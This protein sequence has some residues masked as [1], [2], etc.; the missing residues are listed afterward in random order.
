MRGVV[1]MLLGVILLVLNDALIKTLTLGYPV[2]QLLFLRGLFVIP[3]VLMLATRA[4][5][6]RALRVINVK[7]QAWRGA[8]VIAGSF[9]FVSGL[10][11]LPL[12]DAVAISFTGPLFITAMAPYALGERVGWRRRGAVLAGFLGVLIMARPGGEALQLAVLLPLGAALC[13]GVRDLITRRIARSETTVSMLFVT[14]SVVMLAGLATV[15]LGWAPLDTADLWTF[16]ASGVL[17]AGAHYLMIEAFRHG[18][19]ALVAPFK[20]TT[21][22]WAVLFGYLFF[23]DLP[24]TWTLAGAAVVLL[25]GLYILHRETRKTRT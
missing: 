20:Y 6:L 7:G 22:V 14:T 25:A 24:D 4:G 8:C 18:E 17:V 16:A 13:G 10:R 3:W 2:G 1:C 11:H 5:G 12:A 23:G 21:M 19:A 15:P 9:L